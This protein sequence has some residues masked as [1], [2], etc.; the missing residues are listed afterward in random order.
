MAVAEFK[1]NGL[2][3]CREQQLAGFLETVSYCNSAVGDVIH[4]VS[5][6]S[7]DFFQLIVRLAVVIDKA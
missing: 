3:Q 1:Q 4:V 5:A 7:H 2:I 6:R